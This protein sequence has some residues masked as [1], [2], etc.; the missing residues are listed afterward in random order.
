MTDSKYNGMFKVSSDKRRFYNS[1][2]KNLIEHGFEEK[3]K[4]D[5]RNGAIYDMDGN[6]IEDSGQIKY[7]QTFLIA[8]LKLKIIDTKGFF[9]Y[10]FDYT[11]DKDA[12][13][14]YLEFGILNHKDLHKGTKDFLQK[15]ID[16]KRKELI[17]PNLSL[18]ISPDIIRKNEI[19]MKLIGLVGSHNHSETIQPVYYYI[20]D[21]L[22]EYNISP[23]EAKEIVLQMKGSVSP[24][25][26]KNV[27]PF[28]V[29]HLKQIEQISEPQ[30]SAKEPEKIE[31]N[32]RI[33]TSLKGFM[34]FDKLVKK[35]PKVSDT[36]S[37]IYLQLVKDGYI[38]KDITH[39]EI[40][41]FFNSE[42]YKITIDKI[43]TLN[44][45]ENEQR[46]A[47]YSSVLDSNK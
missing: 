42:P 41:D 27:I 4:Y 29:E 12:F 25:W 17:A 37:F 7:N 19:A 26:N 44:V 11:P 22:K 9:N 38:F 6:F 14:D 24:L 31:F 32:T 35:C 23:I 10:H 13:L 28:I 34:L 15:L 16:E 8:V 18:L 45:L 43:K 46:M 40:K 47:L 39:K 1:Q 30:Q 33:F 20:N 2:T 21:V 36:Y 3:C 5:L